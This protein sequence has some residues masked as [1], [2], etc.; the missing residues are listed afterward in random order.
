MHLGQV[1]G[2]VVAAVKTPSL[3]GHRMLI[4]QPYTYAR[5]PDGAAFVAIDLVSAGRGEWVFYVRAREAANALP[6]AFNPVDR[7]ILGIVDEIT[8]A[9]LEAEPPPGA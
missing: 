7:A 2:T 4:V 9:R 3:G 8:L 6:N 5:A 1:I